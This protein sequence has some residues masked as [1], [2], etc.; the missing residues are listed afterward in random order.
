MIFIFLKIRIPEGYD[1]ECQVG[2]STERFSL[3]AKDVGK[4]EAW[5]EWEEWDQ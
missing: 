5:G 1:R 2:K 4:W 3:E